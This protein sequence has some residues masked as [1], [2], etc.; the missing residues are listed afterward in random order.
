MTFLTNVIWRSLDEDWPA[1]MPSDECLMF[2]N[3]HLNIYAFDSLD[4]IE[5]LFINH[6][7]DLSD[8][9]LENEHP[10][11]SDYLINRYRYTHWAPRPAPPD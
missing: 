8:V 5:M 6:Q 4:G 1:D 10:D 3:A 2:Y 11:V 9:D 7:Q